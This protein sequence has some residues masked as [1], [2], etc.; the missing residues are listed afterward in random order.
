MTDVELMRDLVKIELFA[1]DERPG[2]A[3]FYWC[4]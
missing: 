3:G 4:I 1:E 2:L